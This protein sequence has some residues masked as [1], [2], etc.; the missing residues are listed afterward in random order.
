MHSYRCHL[1][2]TAEKFVDRTVVCSCFLAY[3]RSLKFELQHWSRASPFN[4]GAL[5]FHS[6]DW[7][8]TVLCLLGWILSYRSLYFIIQ[9]ALLSASVEKR[10]VRSLAIGRARSKAE[11]Q[12]GLPECHTSQKTS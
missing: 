5:D 12:I 11:I 2:S 9:P 8:L 3:R 4:L 1:Q 7:N 10:T 6:L